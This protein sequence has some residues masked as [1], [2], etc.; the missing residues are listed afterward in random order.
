[1]NKQTTDQKKEYGFEADQAKDNRDGRQKENRHFGDRG[2]L[3]QTYAGA[4][5]S[6]AQHAVE[7]IVQAAPTA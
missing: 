7:K 2:M 3:F 1:M 5:L 6:P 4:M